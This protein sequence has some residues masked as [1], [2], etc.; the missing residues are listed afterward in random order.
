MT[1]SIA[2]IIADLRASIGDDT[3][4]DAVFATTVKLLSDVLGDAGE[5]SVLL[6]RVTDDG[7]PQH[8][9]V[10]AGGPVVNFIHG[11]GM[12]QIACLATLHAINDAAAT[13]CAD[14]PEALAVLDRNRVFVQ[15][16]CDAINHSSRSAVS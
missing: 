6:I 11:L 2:R 15:S 3:A 5:S 10:Q 12:I 16:I 1:D 8:C 14:I 4:D 13:H 9:R 7:D